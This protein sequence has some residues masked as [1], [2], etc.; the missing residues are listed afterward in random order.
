MKKKY[1][2]EHQKKLV[3]YNQNGNV[4]EEPYDLKEIVKIESI[5]P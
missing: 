2:F 5:A 3:K 1:S 4:C